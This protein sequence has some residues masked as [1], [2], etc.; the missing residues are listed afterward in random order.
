MDGLRPGPNRVV[1]VGLLQPAANAAKL[2]LKEDLTPR[3]PNGS[4]TRVAI[5]HSVVPAISVMSSYRGASSSGTWAIA[6]N[7]GIL[8]ILA[9]SRSAYTRSCM[10]AGLAVEVRQF[11]RPITPQMISYELAMSFS[12]PSV[13]C[14]SRNHV[15]RWDR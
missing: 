6:S 1:P 2:I 11:G 8:F 3:L 10:A 7:A 13:C 4:H 9:I 12:A 5:G 15:A 14:L